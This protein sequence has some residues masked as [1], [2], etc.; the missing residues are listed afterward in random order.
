M[1]VAELEP[2]R[3]QE[4]IVRRG[5]GVTIALLLVA[6]VVAAFMVDAEP[7]LNLDA[8]PAALQRAVAAVRDASTLKTDG[9]VAVKGGGNSFGLRF[10]S[11]NDVKRGV[12]KFSMEFKTDQPLPFP[13]SIQ[14]VGTAEQLFVR[15]PSGE[16]WLGASL[17]D[18]ESA[19]AQFGADQNAFLAYL[20]AL[21]G[22][23]NPGPTESIRGVKTQRFDVQAEVARLPGTTDQQKAAVA[24]LAA[25]GLTELPVSIWL[26]EEGRLRRLVLTVKVSGTKSVTQVD[27]YD[28]GTPV[29][30]EL[31]PP[32]EVETL[33]SLQTLFAR[34][35]I[36]YALPQG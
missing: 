32:D 35:G 9:S 8:S 36:P 29:T 12:S 4:G 6:A 11:T 31:P 5:L 10:R 7:G 28:Y 16:G 1:T 24:Q 19:A 2:P 18:V 30:I 13:K 26:D 17:A 3:N 34:L 33:E 22:A 21:A 15:Q 23:A 20:D 27:Y 14:M 25:A